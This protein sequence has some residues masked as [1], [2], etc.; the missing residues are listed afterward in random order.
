VNA[1]A[2]AA[3]AAVRGAYGRLLAWLAWQWRDIAAAEDALSQA[4]LA[5]LE[6]WP[7]DGVPASPEGWLMTAARRNLLKAERHRRVTEDPLVTVL[8]PGEGSAVEAAAPLPD[9]R[10]RLMLVCAHPA[11][12]PAI[13]PALMLQVVLGLD[14]ARI[15]RALL[16]PPATLGKRLVRAKAKI[17]ATGIRFEE[18]DLDQLPQR[19]EAVLEAIYGAYTLDW[20][21]EPA[22]DG[23]SLAHEALFLARL[24]AT[25]AP[26]DAEALGLA[27]L[28]E[29][30]EEQ[31]PSRWDMALVEAANARL[32][33]A[34]ALRS[35]GPFQLE[36]AI[37]LAH[38][39]PARGRRTPW[40]DI[41]GLYEGLL[42]LHPSA[43]AAIGHALAAAIAR[44]DPH[45]GLRL[46]DEVPLAARQAHQPWWA[47]RAHLLATAGRG[48]QAVEAYER[49]LALTRS[50]AV[51]R[52]L[53]ERQREAAG[54]Q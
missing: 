23:D 16:V 24:V 11:I 37:Q 12:D 31:D 35:M 30:C 25:L 41:V 39:E 27:A 45:A 21:G 52:F 44:Q 26:A 10:L 38:C 34:C 51:R 2:A 3:E 32:G 47:A 54:V 13:R 4:L 1:A 36:A 9:H 6:T 53:L 33:T 46:L 43:G 14:A 7:R 49:A 15:A 28:L 17:K 20:D 29:A 18:P 19:R 50:S 48:T 40:A 42:A 8:L 5:A 22:Q